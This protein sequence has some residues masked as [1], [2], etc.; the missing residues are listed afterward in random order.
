M[1]SE[2]VE[3]DTRKN[4]EQVEEVPNHLLVTLFFLF[5]RDSAPV[6]N[7]TKKI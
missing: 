3:H 1:N 2:Q 7:I 4:W 6:N 5:K